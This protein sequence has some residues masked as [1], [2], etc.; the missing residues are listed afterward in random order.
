MF[1]V[2]SSVLQLLFPLL[3]LTANGLLPICV[4]FAI[5]A[6]PFIARSACSPL[7]PVSCYRNGQ[8]RAE[9]GADGR[10]GHEERAC[11]Q[12][13]A[14]HAKGWRACVLR[15]RVRL[16]KDRFCFVAFELCFVVVFAVDAMRC[17]E[18]RNVAQFHPGVR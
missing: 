15:V 5:A 8:G 14:T 6:N 13:E 18:H 4:Y 17:N 11:C 10:S 12:A 16:E 2:L 3:S 7:S 1:P 9:R